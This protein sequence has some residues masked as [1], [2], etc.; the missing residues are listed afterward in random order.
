MSELYAT[1][2]NR[3]TGEQRELSENP[4]ATVPDPGDHIRIDE[5][6]YRVHQVTHTPEE[7]RDLELTVTTAGTAE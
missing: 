2:V 7:S 4:L 3:K 6:L 5:T 1:L